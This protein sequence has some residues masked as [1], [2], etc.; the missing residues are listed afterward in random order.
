MT[1]TQRMSPLDF[2]VAQDDELPGYDEAS[3]APAYE[4]GTYNEPLTTYRLRQYDRKIQMLADYDAP[5]ASSY[6]ITKNS[7]R[8]FSKKPEM[9]VL[10]TSQDMQQ[11]NIASLAFDDYGGF[12]W[13]PRAHFDHTAEDGLSTSYNMESLNFAD[14]T[15][16]VGD[17]AYAWTLGLR[18]VSLIL[19]EKNSSMAIARFTYSEKGVLAVRGAEV[20]ELTIYRD[21][22][23]TGRDGVDKVVCGLVVVLT[24]LKKM[25]KNYTN[26]AD[27]LERAA[28]LTR[29]ALP[30]HR[31]SSAGHYSMGNWAG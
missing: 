5:A 27:G 3:A 14:W 17:R 26:K 11:R 15:F 8:V 9:E 24:F 4:L 18:P 31:G 10:Y 21:S 2:D 13:R 29:E 12:P 19:C 20:G 22:L 30:P 7:F 6:R 28:S 23:T 25:G 1:A 16:T